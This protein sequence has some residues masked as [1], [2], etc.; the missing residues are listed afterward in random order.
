[1]KNLKTKIQGTNNVVICNPANPNSNHQSPQEKNCL[2][3]DFPQ[4][5]FFGSGKETDKL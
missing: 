2:C 4:F 5:N 3:A 1:M